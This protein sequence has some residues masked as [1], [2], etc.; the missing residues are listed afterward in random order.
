MVT[1]AVEEM[2]GLVQFSVALEERVKKGG[3]FVIITPRPRFWMEQKEQ[4]YLKENPSH[5][6]FFGADEGDKGDGDGSD[7]DV[8]DVTDN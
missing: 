2:K 8:V 7:D 1:W 5:A 6:S 3:V 4:E